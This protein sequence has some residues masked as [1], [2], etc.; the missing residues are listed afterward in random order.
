MSINVLRIRVSMPN[1][2]FRIIHSS[3]P[4]RTYPLPPYSTVIGFLA[5]VLGSQKQIGI[6]LKGGLVLGVLSKHD[7]VT[8]EYTWLRNLSPGA[9]TG[10]YG[11][12]DNRTWQGVIEHIGG[13]SPV[14]IEVLNGVHII[15]YIYHPDD[16]LLKTL[17]RNLVCPEKWYSHLHLGRAEDWT[18]IDSASMVTLGISNNPAD[19]RNAKQYFQWM[20]EPNVAFG[21]KRYVNEGHYTELYRKIQGPAM[22]VTSVYSLVRVPYKGKKGKKAKVVGGAIRNFEHIPVR[23]SCSPIPFLDDFTLPA[24]LADSELNVP[25]YM[26]YIAGN[27]RSGGGDNHAR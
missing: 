14:G 3:E 23:L 20:P 2:H 11:S 10:R 18:I 21:I 25:V 9:H 6:M 22:L 4:Q 8:R 15:L 5:N 17:N 27:S 16:S 19:L 26:A 12:L 24:V 7:H 13:Q 1:A